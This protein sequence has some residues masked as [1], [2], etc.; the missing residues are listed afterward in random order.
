MTEKISLLQKYVKNRL[1]KPIQPEVVYE[2][3][4]VERISTSKANCDEDYKY[5]TTNECKRWIECNDNTLSTLRRIL[6][7]E[8][9]CDEQSLVILKAVK[10]PVVRNQA[11]LDRCKRKICAYYE[12]KVENTVNQVD[13]KSEDLSSESADSSE[14]EVIE[15]K[16][17][18][19]EAGPSSSNTTGKKK[20]KFYQPEREK[21]NLRQKRAK[22]KS[23]AP[24]LM[25]VSLRPSQ[26]LFMGCAPTQE[27][28]DREEKHFV[29][30]KCMFKNDEFV[31]SPVKILLPKE[32]SVNEQF[33]DEG[34]FRSVAKASIENIDKAYCV[35]SFKA[36]AS[37]TVVE[38]CNSNFREMAYKAV[39]VSTLSSHFL[40]LF[41]ARVGETTVRRWRFNDCMIV[42]A[43]GGAEAQY[44]HLNFPVM[45][46]EYI[47][48]EDG[49]VKFINNTGECIGGIDTNI[50]SV[51]ESYVHFTYVASKEL[52]MPLDLQGFV[53][54]KDNFVL[55]DPEIASASN[56]Y[57]TEW[58]FACGN[59][60]EDA[61]NK[62]KNDHTCCNLCERLNLPKF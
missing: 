3:E 38:V 35:K 24:S 43:K 59:L 52:V 27:E 40:N 8:L 53:L 33:F 39:Q 6:I 34:T 62:F 45:L 37:A 30:R 60:S 36:D 57:G 29:I 9:N 46:E 12:E 50:L 48:S 61:I 51:L 4:K 16:S 1:N 15:K 28:L 20:R 25:N 10:G 18:T 26:I 23:V 47:E 17:P 5:K 2:V 14:I 21:Y 55:T 7:E 11:G 13:L 41:K 22:V 49:M 32:F 42:E 31:W 58:Q 19:L 54:S 44:P 56:T